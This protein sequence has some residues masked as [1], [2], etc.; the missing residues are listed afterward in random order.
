VQERETRI[1][2]IRC[3]NANLLCW[4]R[5]TLTNKRADSVTFGVRDA[6]D[7]FASEDA[8]RLFEAFYSTKRSGMGI[9]LSVSRSIIQSHQGRLWCDRND[10]PGARF[11]FAIPARREPSQESV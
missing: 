7:G 4:A 5:R 8:E 11:S 9:G 6:G 10:G 1:I 2:A 3:H